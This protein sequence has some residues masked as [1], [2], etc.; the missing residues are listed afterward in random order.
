[1]NQTTHMNQTKTKNTL[2]DV[3]AVLQDGERFYQKAADTVHPGAHQSLFR[4]MAALKGEHAEVVSGWLNHQGLAAPDPDA[5]T[6]VGTLRQAYARAAAALSSNPDATYIGQLEETEDRILNSLKDAITEVRDPSA[7]A[8]LEALL[9]SA[10]REHDEMHR[11][12]QDG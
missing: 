8:Q 6:V 5:G 12:K 1:M 7:R 11:L 4:R 10:Q 3:V 9:P 2:H